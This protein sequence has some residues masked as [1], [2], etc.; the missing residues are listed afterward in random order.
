MKFILGFLILANS[1]G[2]AARDPCVWTRMPL[3]SE[4]I[5][6]HSLNEIVGHSLQSIQCLRGLDCQLKMQL[7]CPQYLGTQPY[8]P[9]AVASEYLHKGCGLPAVFAFDSFSIMPGILSEQAFGSSCV[10]REIHGFH[11][12][13]QVVGVSHW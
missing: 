3:C 2:V 4:Y 10:G 7:N 13:S 11:L 6:R 9:V 1:D 8:F 12:Q 5:A